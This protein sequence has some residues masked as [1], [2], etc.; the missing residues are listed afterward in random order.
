MK[1]PFGNGTCLC[2]EDGVSEYT[3]FGNGI[4]FTLNPFGNGVSHS[5]VAGSKTAS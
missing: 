5:L 1:N 3:P 2:H 4:D